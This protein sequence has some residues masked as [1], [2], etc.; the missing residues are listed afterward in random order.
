MFFYALRGATTVDKNDTDEIILRTKQ[1]LSDIIKKNGLNCDRI[2]SI[3]FTAT[4]DLDAVY[5]AVAA[6]ELGMNEV[7]LICCQEM[8]TANSLPKCLRLLMHVRT[9][10]ETKPQH[11]YLRGAISLRPD[12][13]LNT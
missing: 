9:D 12:L 8:N 1:L 4:I 6:R 13:I 2:V 11:V 10:Y 7:P 5:P 3:I